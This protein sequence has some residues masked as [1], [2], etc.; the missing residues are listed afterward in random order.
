V[1]GISKMS[2]G[3]VKEAVLGVWKMRFGA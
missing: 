2:S 1:E 3:I